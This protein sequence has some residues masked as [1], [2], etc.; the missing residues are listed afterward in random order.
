ML[1][2]LLHFNDLA[3]THFVP[4]KRGDTIQCSLIS[5]WLFLFMWV[6]Q[7]GIQQTRALSL[8]ISASFNWRFFCF[9]SPSSWC[10]RYERQQPA[11]FCSESRLTQHC[12]FDESRFYHS[13]GES[14]IALYDGARNDFQTVQ[15]FLHLSSRALAKTFSVTKLLSLS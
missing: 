14:C 11:A 9:F 3:Q 8:G 7:D 13:A 4:H 12:S 5:F 15:R 10:L 6:N 1:G 2:Q